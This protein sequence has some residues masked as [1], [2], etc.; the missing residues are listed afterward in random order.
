M[1][2][3]MNRLFPWRAQAKRRAGNTLRVW[4]DD[5]IANTTEGWR[6]PSRGYPKKTADER[7]PLWRRTAVLRA[8]RKASSRM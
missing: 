2:I 6:A 1:P 5:W 8:V 7:R 3:Y 4:P